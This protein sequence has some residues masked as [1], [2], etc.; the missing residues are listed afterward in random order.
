MDLKYF[1]SF[2]PLDDAYF[3]TC[4]I[5]I[6]FFW[7]GGVC[8]ENN[9]YF[10]LFFC[11]TVTWRIF[12]FHKQRKTVN[13]FLK[14]FCS[15][16]N[17]SCSVLSLIEASYLVRRYGN[18]WQIFQI[19]IFIPK[20]RICYL[21]PL[22]NFLFYFLFGFQTKKKRFFIFLIGES[23]SFITS[24]DASNFFPF[25]IF[26]FFLFFFW[27]FF[28]LLLLR[29]TLCRFKTRFRA[30][31]KWKNEVNTFKYPLYYWLNFQIFWI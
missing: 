20:A 26:V 8:A 29:L 6:F 4:I 28:W 30:W 16:L 23:P 7:G 15:T 31:L 12:F 21:K 19:F 13:L 2:L 18:W 14:R 11:S 3:W 27:S 1:F 17:F 22:L 9:N 24:F 10:E 25:L 5:S